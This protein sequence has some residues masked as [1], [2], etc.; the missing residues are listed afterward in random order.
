MED[1]PRHETSKGNNAEKGK[2]KTKDG[3]RKL[4][5]KQ[6]KEGDGRVSSDVMCSLKRS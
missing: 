5:C 1:F 4:T 6:V 2:K 3:Q